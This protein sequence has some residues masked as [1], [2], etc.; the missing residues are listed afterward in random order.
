MSTPIHSEQTVT[1]PTSLTDSATQT[2]GKV[3][4]PLATNQLIGTLTEIGIRNEARTRALAELWLRP[5][6]S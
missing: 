2:F 3:L 5:A 1:M 6:S 4:S